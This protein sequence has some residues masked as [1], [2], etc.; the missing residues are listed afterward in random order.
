MQYYLSSFGLHNP[1]INIDFADHLVYP[2]ANEFE[3]GIDLDYGMLL[4]G[5][6]FVID[7]ATYEFIKYDTRTYL[8]PMA[9]SLH[10]LHNEGLLELF[11][12]ESMIEQDLNNLKT[13]TEILAQDFSGWLEL[14]RTQWQELNKYR[15]SFV[16][17]YGSSGKEIIN[18]NHFTLVNAVKTIHGSIDVSTIDQYRS[19]IFSN[20]HKFTSSEKE[21]I[22][23]VIKPLICHILIH[24][25]ARYKT[26]SILLDWDDSAKYYDRLYSSRWDHDIVASQMPYKARQIFNLLIPQLKPDMINQVIKFLNDKRSKSLRNELLNLVNSGTDVDEKWLIHYQNEVYKSGL[27]KENIMKKVRWG[28]SILG[29][30]IPGSTLAIDILKE[31]GSNIL[32]NGIENGINAEK[33]EWYYAMQDNIVTKV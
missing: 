16:N 3:G 2:V 20:K 14:V 7:K 17:T 13:K 18:N 30:I 8:N 27:K 31:A 21:I 23:E 32:E 5:E 28:S 24:D 22:I 19:L 9:N 33:Y 29:L 11:D 6:K 15:S 10:I 1:Y 12:L 25:F 26:D 4:V